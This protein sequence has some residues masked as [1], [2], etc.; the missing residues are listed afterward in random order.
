MNSG[1]M[2]SA[3]DLTWSYASIL[4]ALQARD[5]FLAAREQN[6]DKAASKTDLLTP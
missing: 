6:S 1:V 2:T 5:A 4:S 3:K